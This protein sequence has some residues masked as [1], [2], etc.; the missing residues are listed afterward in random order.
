MVSKI[1]FMLLFG[2]MTLTRPM[3]FSSLVT[4]G[5]INEGT[6]YGHPMGKSVNNN[7]WILGHT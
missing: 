3:F 6:F 1:Y 4:S 5:L 2:M 7:H